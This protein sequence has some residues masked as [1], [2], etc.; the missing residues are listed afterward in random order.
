MQ[1]TRAIDQ[2]ASAIQGCNRERQMRAGQRLAVWLVRCSRSLCLKRC[3]THLRTLRPDLGN[4][5]LRN[6]M[7]TT[8]G[9][10]YITPTTIP[11]M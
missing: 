9:T 6:F 1:R 3:I 10:V 8:S 5:T 7:N 4:N 2:Y 11:P